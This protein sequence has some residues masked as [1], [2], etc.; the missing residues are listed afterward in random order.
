MANYLLGVEKPILGP[1]PADAAEQQRPAPTTTAGAHQQ[2]V[3]NC[4]QGREA[5]RATMGR[6]TISRAHGRGAGDTSKPGATATEP[7]PAPTASTSTPTAPPAEPPT[8]TEPPSCPSCSTHAASRPFDYARILRRVRTDVGSGNPRVRVEA[9]AEE[10][11]EEE[12]DAEEAEADDANDPAP[13][14][15]NQAGADEDADDNTPEAGVAEGD[16]TTRVRTGFRQNKRG[17]R[18][19]LG[20]N[21]VHWN[22]IKASTRCF[23]IFTSNAAEQVNSSIVPIRRLPVTPLL[24]GLM[25]WYRDRYCERKMA[26]RE[27]TALLT[28]AAEERMV[29]KETRAEGYELLGG[30]LEEGTIQTRDTNDPKEWRSFNVNINIELRT[31]DCSNWDQYQFPCSHAVAFALRRELDPCTLV[32]D[33]YTTKNWAE[34]YSSTVKGSCVDRIVLGRKLAAP[35]ECDAPPFRRTAAAR[36]PSYARV[37]KGVHPYTCSVCHLHGHTKNRYMGKYGGSAYP[38]KRRYRKRPKARKS[39]RESA[40]FAGTI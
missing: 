11:D 24:G 28:E 4:R 37:E 9:D 2:A 1:P 32:S 10:D 19:K 40:P 6:A 26:T 18:K 15:G 30:D 22:R 39:Y 12:A 29:L 16:H 31:C 13:A 25:N 3:E 17:T 27:R 20:I 14:E 34:T 8:T 33:F 7:R 5:A 38:E 23:G 21:L 35:G 36:P